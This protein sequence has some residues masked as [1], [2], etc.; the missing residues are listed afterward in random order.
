[1]AWWNDFTTSIAAIPT[2]LKRLTGGGNYLSDEERAKE[3]VL[4]NTVKDALRGIDT[5]LSNVPG[6]GIGK[7]VVKGVGDKLLQG[8]VTLNQEVLSPYIFRPVSTAALLT[9]FQSP[10]YKKGQYEEGFQF[11]DVKAAYNRSA[12]VSIGQALTM[13]DMTPI[14]GLAA[15]VSLA[16]I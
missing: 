1:M 3:E 11:D 5:G 2:A 7:K 13:S 16:S 12:K 15:V 8:A 9:D 6:F 14:S 4:H 10:L